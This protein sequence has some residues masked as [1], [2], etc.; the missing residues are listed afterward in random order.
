MGNHRIRIR[1]CVMHR[2]CRRS[3]GDYGAILLNFCC[4]GKEVV[5]ITVQEEELLEATVKR[6]QGLRLHN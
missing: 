3:S 4:G 2:N 6:W 5:W 1:K